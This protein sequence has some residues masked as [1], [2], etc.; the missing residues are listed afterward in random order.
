M[1]NIKYEDI[2]SINVNGHRY[3]GKPLGVDI[4]LRL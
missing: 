1:I 4:G 2:G 3:K